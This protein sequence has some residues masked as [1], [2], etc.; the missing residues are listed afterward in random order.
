M[1]C[2]RERNSIEFSKD[3]TVE[4]EKPR[5]D[6]TSSRHLNVVKPIGEDLIGACCFSTI[7][8]FCLCGN[9]SLHV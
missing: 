7:G 2:L 5:L 4:R 1:N 8:A 9:S 3:L 6:R